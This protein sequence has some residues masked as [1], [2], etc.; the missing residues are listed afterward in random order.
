MESAIAQS[1]QESSEIDRG[2]HR[3]EGVTLPDA[4]TMAGY[5]LGVWWSL[6]GPSWAGVASVIADEVDGRLARATGTSTQHGSSLDWGADIA[7]TPL[8]LARLGA[9]IRQPMLAPIAAP[10]V[11][12]AQAMLRGSE[13][14]P[15]IGSA[16]AVVTLVT[17]GVHEFKK[18][19]SRQRRR[20]RQAP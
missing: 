4:V 17:I 19:K 2:S 15:S 5:F 12:L 11:L 1:G 18:G 3:D 16:R 20:D 7:L 6:G 14:R 13:A 8:A 9:E 10:P